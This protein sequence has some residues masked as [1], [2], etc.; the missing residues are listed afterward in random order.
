[1]HPDDPETI[2]VDLSGRRALVIATNHGVLDVGKPTGVFAS[3]LTVPYYAFLGAGMEVDVASPER[4]RDPRRP[5]V[6][7]AG[8]AHRGVRPLPRPTTS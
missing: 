4:R 3:E 2:E 8:V 5:A 7:E 6:P 1:M